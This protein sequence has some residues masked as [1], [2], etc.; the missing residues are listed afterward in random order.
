M[1]VG[2]PLWIE[3][4][5][6]RW[7][8][9]DAHR[10]LKPTYE[11]EA[12]PAPPPPG[13]EDYERELAMVQREHL[14]C[15][16]LFAEYKLNRTRQDLVAKGYD[17]NRPRIPASNPGGGRWTDDGGASDQHRVR[18]AGNIPT[19]D[20]PEFPQNKPSDP[21]QKNAAIKTAARLLAK[22]GGP[23]G[24]IVGGAYWLFEYEADIKANLDPPKSLEALKDDVSK[25]EAGYHVH[26]IVEQT[27]AERD[28]YP[29]TMIDERDNLVR[30][31]A[32][33]HREITGWYQTRNEDFGYL[34]P[35]DYLK[36][37]SWEER[38]RV[39]LSALMRFGVLEP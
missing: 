20:T 30:I 10:W 37:K 6:K 28:G 35:R 17:P 7:M 25:R 8:L 18:L 39:G 31:P 12:R 24:K 4:Q 5:C 36:G 1:P 34:S 13:D 21:D 23:L 9:H 19:D 15:K 32:M 16:W 11:P 38:R 14:K 26:H 22:Y 27:S 29:R 2:H 3:L 33:K